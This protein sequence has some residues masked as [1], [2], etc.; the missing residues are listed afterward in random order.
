MN[1][2]SGSELLF[3]EYVCFEIMVLMPL[4]STNLCRITLPFQ[5][6]HRFYTKIGSRHVADTGHSTGGGY[7]L[8][9]SFC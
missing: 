8:M 9:L 2:N 1:G 7:D 5:S 4:N 6:H 3:Y